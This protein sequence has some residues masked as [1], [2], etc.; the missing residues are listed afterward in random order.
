MRGR[1]F[2]LLDVTWALLQLLSLAAGG[3]VV[4]QVGIRPVY[5]GGGALLFLPASATSAILQLAMWDTHHCVE[6][7]LCDG[8]LKRLRGGGRQVTNGAYSGRRG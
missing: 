2:T 7:W 5:W 6:A 3:L 4:D 1:V 8:L